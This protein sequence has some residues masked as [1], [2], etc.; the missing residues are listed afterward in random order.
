MLVEPASLRA[1]RDRVGT[2]SSG[3]RTCDR[4]HGATR[5]PGNVRELRNVLERAVALAPPPGAEGRALPKFSSLV[6]NLGP[7]MEEPLTL[8]PSYPGVAS[9][10]PYK[11]AKERLLSEFDR[12]YLDS[13]MARHHG[14]VTRAAAA[15]EL[16]RKHLYELMRRSGG[17][18]EAGHGGGSGGDGDE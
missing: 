14:N 5:W 8:G 18:G 13:L 7:A 6:L 3:D 4:L 2:R 11:E 16:S 10:L 9:P 17:G 12:A 15:A 1:A